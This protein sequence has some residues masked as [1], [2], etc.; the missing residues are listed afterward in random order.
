LR[1]VS[2]NR[3]ADAPAAQQ[4]LHAKAAPLSLERGVSLDDAIAEIFSAC[5]DHFATNLIALRTGG[6]AEAVHQMRVA[7]RRLRALFGLVRRVAPF[8]ELEAAALAAKAL[9]NLLGPARDWRVLFHLLEAE[10]PGMLKTERGYPALLG[11]V[12]ARALEAEATAQT[13]IDSPATEGFL[14]DMR[15]LIAR[16]AWTSDLAETSA[17]RF[18]RSQIARLHRRAR[19]RCADVAKLSPERRHEA[20]IALKKVRY[21]TEFFESLFEAKRTRD[22]ARE[23]SGLQETLG[24]DHDWTTASRLLSEVVR[25]DGRAE[26]ER[27]ARGVLAARADAVRAHLAGADRAAK[28]LK[29]ADRFWR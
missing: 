16:R 26:V 14:S 18:A 3:S 19:R 24:D 20:R 10:Q 15:E 11:A 13:A 5:I 2:D 8:P 28:R 27:A 1:L 4:T 25:A 22:Y 12:E 29:R 9:A 7:L 21:A 23:V 6:G 17:R